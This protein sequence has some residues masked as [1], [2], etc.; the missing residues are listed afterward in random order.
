MGAF[1][2]AIA[3]VG[4]GLME[5]NARKRALEEDVALKQK[6]AG[7]EY[8]RELQKAKVLQQLKDD[9]AAAA[10]AAKA[11]R[12]QFANL[13]DGQYAVHSN[14]PDT[15][16]LSVRVEGERRPTKGQI[17]TTDAGVFDYDSDTGGMKRLGNSKPS[18][19]A[20][21]ND[22]SSIVRDLDD[23]WSRTSTQ[24]DLQESAIKS[25]IASLTAIDADNKPALEQ[26]IKSLSDMKAKREAEYK[27]RRQEVMGGSSPAAPSGA[28]KPMKERQG[29]LDIFT[30]AVSTAGKYGGT[31]QSTVEGMASGAVPFE[32][33][34][35]TLSAQTGK[36]VTV[37]LDGNTSEVAQ[38]PN[39][40]AQANKDPAVAETYESV[41]AEAYAQFKSMPGISDDVAK[42]EAEKIAAP[43]KKAK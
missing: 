15:G 31:E 10:E 25:K 11:A 38:P 2:R 36:P 1:G 34:A 27:R 37:G 12:E 6:Y 4:K 42:A 32:V 8:E 35:K 13:G 9:N 17:I 18:A 16:K 5:R 19:P 23:Q 14:D 3:D 26:E 40:Q 30:D 28:V 33:A 39:P 41:Y 21:W 20:A 22:P 43:Y 24:F 7:E 29:L